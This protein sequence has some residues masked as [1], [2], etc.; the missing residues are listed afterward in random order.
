[1]RSAGKL[2]NK[3][4]EGQEMTD[5]Q[6]EQVRRMVAGMVL[7]LAGFFVSLIIS[8]HFGFNAPAAG[9]LAGL[10]TPLCAI[11]GYVRVE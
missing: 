5:E 3:R 8:S 9:A 10:V 6:I 7:G 4:F 1:M 2:R 11:A